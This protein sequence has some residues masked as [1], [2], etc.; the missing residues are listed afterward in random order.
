VDA[1]IIDDVDYELRAL[2]EL[3]GILIFP[4]IKGVVWA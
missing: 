3:G 1:E 2:D 4:S